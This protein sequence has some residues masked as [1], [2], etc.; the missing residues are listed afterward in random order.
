MPLVQAEI[1]RI[2]QK[3]RRSKIMA[4]IRK[5]THRETYRA[6]EAMKQRCD[7]PTNPKDRKNYQDRGISYTPDW[8]PYDNFI[9]D[10]GE[11]PEG[12]QLDRKD[13]NKGYSKENC[14]WATARE[15]VN[16]RRM[17]PNA[18]SGCTGVSF[19]RRDQKWMAY[20]K[21]G[22]TM[23]LLYWGVDFFEA[24]CARKSWENQNVARL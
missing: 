4:A 13:N 11:K 16:N 7:N 19:V 8:I 6:W 23:R 20:P 21:R 3:A 9:R 17:L 12:Y 24:C 10:M 18:S 2:C 1:F 22:S 5:G 14:R 15:Q